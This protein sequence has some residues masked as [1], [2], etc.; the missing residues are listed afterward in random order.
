MYSVLIFLSINHQDCHLTFDLKISYT[1]IFPSFDIKW[2]I[3][4]TQV[5]KLF[6][7]AKVYIT[8]FIKTENHSKLNYKYT[9][10]IPTFKIDWNPHPKYPCK[11]NEYHLRS[12][13][14]DVCGFASRF[15]LFLLVI[16]FGS[17]VKGCVIR[18]VNNMHSFMRETSSAGIIN[19]VERF[20]S[21]F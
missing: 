12:C 21:R 15:A 18:K 7:K 8:L 6:W 14:Q 20:C 13:K 1:Y 5:L 4:H 2:N 10:L 11:K 9:Q 19:C 17:Y 3:K 16:E